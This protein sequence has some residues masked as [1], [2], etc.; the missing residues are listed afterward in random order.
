MFCLESKPSQARCPRRPSIA[1]LKCA[2]AHLGF[3]LLPFGL[4]NG[5]SGGNQIVV[6]SLACR[7]RFSSA[8]LAFI[9]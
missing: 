2:A 3:D 5:P 7:A 8:W 9:F 1:R 6:L 4:Q